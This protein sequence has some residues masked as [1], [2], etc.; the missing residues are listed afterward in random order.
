VHLDQHV[1]AEANVFFARVEWML[2]SFRIRRE[3]VQGAVED[4]VRPFD[5][6]FLALDFTDRRQKVA[7]S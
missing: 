7:S 1:D 4:L 5:P 2:G 3:G 6:T